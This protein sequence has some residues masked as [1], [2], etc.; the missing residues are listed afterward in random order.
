MT[1]Q[2]P[3]ATPEATLNTAVEEFYQPRIF[4]FSGRIGR[5]RYLAYNFSLYFI[6]MLLMMPLMGGAATMT[7]PGN[8]PLTMIVIGV[9]FYALSIIFS[10]MFAKRRFN[11]INR[12]GWYILL[13]L[14]PIVNIAVAVALIFFSGSKE[15]NKFGAMPTE[16]TLWVKIL[17]LSFPILFFVGI[18]AAIS[19]PAFQ[20]YTE[21]AQ[22]MQQ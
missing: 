12:S 1:E 13:L 10:V 7:E 21:K 19:I 4:S 9:I 20:S 14:I 2:S 8:P 6:S 18:I 22:Q 3:Y 15:T 5:L 16:N 11:D 17:G